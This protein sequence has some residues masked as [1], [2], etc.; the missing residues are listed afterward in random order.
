MSIVPQGFDFS[1]A[2]GNGGLW[3]LIFFWELAGKPENQRPAQWMRLPETV[4]LIEQLSKELNVGK[5]HI[6]KTSR[7]KGGGT[8]A[9]WKLALD[10]AG[11]LSVEL[12][13]AYYDWVRDRIEEESNPDLAASRGVDRA[14]AGWKRQGKSDDWIEKRLSTIA[15]RHDFTKTLQE[16]GCTKGFQFGACTNAIYKPV[17]GGTA[18][19][20]KESRGIKK[21][22]K[23]RDSLSRVELMAV[24]LA[25]AIA[26]EKMEQESI[27]TFTECA[28]ISDAAGQSVA[29]A[30]K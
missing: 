3:S 1:E 17:L 11:Y 23:L 26:A 25:E 5:S 12:R 4:K 24:G 27:Q 28:S 30:L 29:K 2:R 22:G 18:E 6:I 8:F 16:H 13:S 20:V 14:I 15:N 21:S 10:Y 9:H 7:G 19:A